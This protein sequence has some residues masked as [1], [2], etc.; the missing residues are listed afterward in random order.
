MI[1][2]EFAGYGAFFILA[3]LH[4]WIYLAS[5]FFSNMVQGKEVIV[6]C[7]PS[8]NDVFENAKG[9]YQAEFKFSPPGK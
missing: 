9:N 2:H 4:G 5:T 7:D 6:V 1:S 8:Y 3:D